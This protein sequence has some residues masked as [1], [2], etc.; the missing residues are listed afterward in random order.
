MR[1]TNLRLL[2]ICFVKSG[3]KPQ[4]QLHGIIVSPEM[5]EIEMGLV[6]KHVIVHRLDLYAVRPQSAKHRINFAGQQ[7][8]ITR[9]RGFTLA[10][11]LKV[12]C[13]SCAHGGR[14]VHSAIADLL[15]PWN[16]ELQDASVCLSGI[17]K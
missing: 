8:E 3:A 6:E 17:A 5:H 1:P 4:R 9:D 13:S 16:R 14:Y 12:D 2:R 15:H 11:G 10:R 7:D